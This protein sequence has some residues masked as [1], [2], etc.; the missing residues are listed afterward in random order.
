MLYLIVVG[1]RLAVWGDEAVDAERTV[2]GLVAEVATVEESLPKPLRKRG[3]L[4][5]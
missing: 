1:M 4:V 3:C 2:V 5:T